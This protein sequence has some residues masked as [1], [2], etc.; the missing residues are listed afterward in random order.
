MAYKR[1][2]DF[3]VTLDKISVEV[4]TPTGGTKPFAS[5]G[6]MFRQIRIV[7]G[8]PIP[9]GDKHSPRH[10]PVGYDEVREVE[11]TKFYWPNDKAFETLVLAKYFIKES[12]AKDVAEWVKGEFMKM[13]YKHKPH[14]TNM[15]K[16]NLLYIINERGPHDECLL[17]LDERGRIFEFEVESNKIRT[18]LTTRK[19]VTG[20]NRKALYSSDRERGDGSED[21]DQTEARRDEGP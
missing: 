1:A 3:T 9:T 2:A 8:L 19:K 4:N 13:G 12:S 21:G 11:G 10:L 18:V 7:Y 17:T 6:G 16:H 15:T 20:K 5:F 14:I